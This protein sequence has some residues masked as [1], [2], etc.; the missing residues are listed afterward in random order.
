M[1]RIQ[2]I[3]NPAS[4]LFDITVQYHTDALPEWFAGLQSILEEDTFT[5]MEDDR[6]KPR[7]GMIQ[8]AMRDFEAEIEE[9]LYVGD[10]DEDQAA[11]RA[12]SVDFCWAE[13]F[14]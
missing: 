3:N 5:R 9:T 7:P 10:R 1:V 13:E 4:S 6:R 14:F 11:A 2:E 12:A 8:D